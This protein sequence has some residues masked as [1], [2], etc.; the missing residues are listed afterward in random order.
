MSNPVSYE[1]T[2][3][4][5]VAVQ[6]KCYSAADLTGIVEEACRL[7]IEKLVNSNS[8]VTIPLTRQMFEEAFKKIPPSL[9]MKMVEAYEKF[10]EDPSLLDMYYGK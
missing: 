3:L 8:K 5:E 10:R 7:A 6:D 1:Q 9:S 2:Y 4:G